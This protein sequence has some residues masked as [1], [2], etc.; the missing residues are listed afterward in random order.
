MIASFL[1][2][3]L[4][5]FI[6][7]LLVGRIGAYSSG[8][9]HGMKYVLLQEHFK[10]KYGFWHDVAI[11]TPGTDGYLLIYDDKTK[12]YLCGR[13]DAKKAVLYANYSLFKWH[14]IQKD[15]TKWCFTEDIM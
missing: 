13:W 6:V 4:G 15:F 11:N 7:G 1:L 12:D 9:S 10:N 14:D 3:Y 2:P 8:M 5:V